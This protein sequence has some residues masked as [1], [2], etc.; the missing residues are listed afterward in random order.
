VPRAEVDLAV[1]RAFD[2]FDVVAFYADVREFEQ[3][4][5]DWGAEFRDR[6]L[7]D[8]TRGGHPH[9][10]AWDMRAKTPD[11]TAACA[12]FL[13]DVADRAVTQDG[14]SRLRRHVLNARRSPNKW[15]VSISKSGRE[16]PDKIDLAV[17]AVGARQARRDVVDS[18]KLA[19][20]KVRSGRVW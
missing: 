7:I 2:R 18:G 11:F 16:S 13:V 12:R 9:P 5:D 19:K 4:I 17:C 15:G 20:R 3:Y 10:V 14:D 6:L 8:A 1:R